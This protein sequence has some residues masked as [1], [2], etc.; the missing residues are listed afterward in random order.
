M[1]EAKNNKVH[2]LNHKEK[3][4]QPYYDSIN[5]STGLFQTGLLRAFKIWTTSEQTPQAELPIIPLR[6]N[7]NIDHGFGNEIYL[8]SL[9]KGSY[10]KPV[11]TPNLYFNNVPLWMGFYGLMDFILQD[12]KNKGVFFRPH[13]CS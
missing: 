2:I 13:V 6:Y 8:T 9:V 7:P 11:Y 12:T 4:Q 3:V 5:F 1:K 10:D